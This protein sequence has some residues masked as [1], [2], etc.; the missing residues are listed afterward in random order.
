MM[1][2]EEI[3]GNEEEMEGDDATYGNAGSYHLTWLYFLYGVGTT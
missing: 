1:T 3:E 2:S